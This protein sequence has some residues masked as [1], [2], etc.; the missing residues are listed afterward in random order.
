[1]SKFEVFKDRTGEWRWRL[2]DGNNRII[3]V[4]GESFT[5]SADANRSLGNVVDE[6][7]QSGPAEV[8]TMIVHREE[9]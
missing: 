9:D 6:I 5:R 1:M 3:A 2:V 8:R 4:S 7:R